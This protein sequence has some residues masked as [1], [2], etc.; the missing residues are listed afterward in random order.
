ME[1]ETFLLTE[2]GIPEDLSTP[3]ARVAEEETEEETKS[4]ITKKFK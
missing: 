3:A 1:K 2:E 4:G